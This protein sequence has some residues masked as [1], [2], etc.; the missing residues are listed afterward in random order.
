MELLVGETL[1]ERIERTGRLPL[2]EAEELAAQMVAGLG[3]AH[4]AGVVHRDFKSSNVILVDGRAVVTDFGL[5]LAVH[6]G[7][8]QTTGIVGSPAYMAPEQLLGQPLSAAADL[9]ALGVVLF[10]MTTGQLPFIAATSMATAY[11]RLTEAPPRPRLI[12]PELGERWERAI[13]RCLEREPARRFASVAELGTALAERV[14]PAPPPRPLWLSV[15]AAVLLV[16]ASAGT[17]IAVRRKL[18]GA[19]AAARPRDA[20]MVPALRSLGGPPDQAWRATAL[21]EMIGS[22]LASGGRLRVVA[23]DAPLITRARFAVTGTY[24]VT[25]DPHDPQIRVEVS[26]RDLAR[27]AVVAS[28]SE[29][30][31]DSQLFD[32][33]ARLGTRLRFALGAGALSHG[34][35]RAV[36]SSLPTTPEALRLYSEALDCHRR[37]DEKGALEKVQAAITV[38]PQ[39]PLPH[40]LLSHIWEALDYD[41]RAADEAAR[42]FERAAALSEPERVAVEARHRQMTHAWG[43]A[44]R[45]YQRLTRQFPDEIEYAVQLARSLRSDHRLDEADAV[46]ARWRHLPSPLRDD[47]RLDFVEA[48]NADERH[49]GRRML[50]AAQSMTDKAEAQGSP[51]MLAEAKRAQAV[52]LLL[53]GEKRGAQTMAE[54]ARQQ[55]LSIGNHL[56]AAKAQLL[57]GCAHKQLGE[58]A[59]ARAAHREVEAEARAA[60]NLALAAF[61][62]N[63]RGNV[64]L[65]LGEYDEALRLYDTAVTL[66]REA[67]SGENVDDLLVQTLINAGEAA[68]KA[69]RLQAARSYDERALAAARTGHNREA[70]QQALVALADARGQ[71]GELAAALD[72]ATQAQ[73]LSRE[74]SDEYQQSE[75]DASL[76]Y[77]LYESGRLEAAQATFARGF[78]VAVKHKGDAGRG[79]C[80]RGLMLVARARHDLETAR[81]RLADALALAEAEHWTS[82]I[83]EDQ[84]ERAR[85]L[86]DEGRWVQAR[87]E[88]SAAAAALARLHVPAQ[89]GEAE[90]VRAEALLALHDLVGARGAIARAMQLVPVQDRLGQWALAITAARLRAAEGDTSAALRGLDAVAAAAQR[91]GCV[92]LELEAAAQRAEIERAAGRPAAYTHLESVRR[93]ANAAGFLIIGDAIQSRLDQHTT[94]TR[95]RRRAGVAVRLPSG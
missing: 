11:K 61:A 54:A 76:G 19:S 5:A 93:R 88:A 17:T 52:A 13:L 10:E 20:V 51:L 47:P 15:L 55:Y 78:A 16:L 77:W 73:M 30:D 72:L 21:S 53:V 85:L 18:D 8:A 26:L 92:R 95:S 87:A 79:M 49:D 65:E 74:L 14:A 39:H 24:T 80:A 83:A 91:A 23:G 27:G 25:G 71:L 75:A 67:V 12:V 60:G 37:Y 35:E 94:G 86:A 90:R 64:A 82:E 81:A 63:N 4:Q 36:R 6:D 38:D 33:V 68:S 84:T 46:I 70:E 57:V 62:L 31:R 3:A 69:G 41:T 7:D 40:L 58:W 34:E 2:D 66:H 1:R 42:A 29:S 59:E 28:F 56:G 32:V 48:W 44:A 9:Y 50:A 43:E 22:E 45:L 89:E